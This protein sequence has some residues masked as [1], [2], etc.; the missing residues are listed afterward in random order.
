MPGKIQPP[1]MQHGILLKAKNIQDY[2]GKIA[3]VL[4]LSYLVVRLKTEQFF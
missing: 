1:W 3:E 4:Y 2:E